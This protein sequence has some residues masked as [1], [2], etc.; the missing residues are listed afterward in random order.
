METLERM[1][2]S[3]V[4]AFTLASTGV[5]A[6]G[7]AA[8]SNSPS[9]A[10][11]NLS[12]Q[13]IADTYIYL[14][15]RLLVL[16]QEQLDFDK[17]GFHWNT[18]IHRSPGGVDWVNPNLDVVYSEAWL[19]VDERTCVRLDIP[20]IEGRYYS[21]HVLNGWGE[22]VLNI[23][24]RTFP[25]H[26]YGAYA[27]CLEGSQATVPTGLLRVDLPG[28]T[29]RVLARVEQGKDP[30]E[31]IRLQHLF[32]LS[33]LGEAKI[34]PF[35][36]I[37]LF[38]NDKLPQAEAFDD[39]TEILL[40]EPDINPG[41]E[42]V[43]SKIKSVEALAKSG[44]GD[45]QRVVNAI[46][47]TAWPEL[48]SS[49]KTLLAIGKM[50]NGWWHPVAN[51][52]YGA[53]YRMRTF[54]NLTG[55]WANSATEATYA[56]KAEIDGSKHF[57]MTFPADNLPKK[58]AR[59]FWSVIMVDSKNYRVIDNPLHRYLLNAQSQLS[60]NKDGSLTLGFGPTLPKG[61]MKSNWLPSPASSKYNLTFRYYGPSEDVVRGEFFPP[62]LEQQP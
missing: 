61:V 44:S 58:K 17:G 62:A 57:T 35:V 54:A 22:T 15:G 53:N 4:F 34:E 32:K 8:P 12:E 33:Q 24:E 5:S 56:G 50:G 40:S 39:A 30:K 46:T 7:I 21:W 31:A 49:P 55:L 41:M 45:R 3:V 6:E 42:D 25:E 19:A 13:D 18:L 1:V 23:N 11:A 2:A 14:L 52:S 59:Y 51:G 29:S 36:K 20:K 9:P 10:A 43:R 47:H 27:L 38:D 16:R 28:K 48:Q 26:P 37:P 60:Y